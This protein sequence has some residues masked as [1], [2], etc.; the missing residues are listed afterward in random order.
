M[1]V[2]ADAD[3]FKGWCDCWR[4][5]DGWWVPGCHWTLDIVCWKEEVGTVGEG[6][7]RL[8]G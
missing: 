1:A 4:R 8:V 2:V 5:D 7:W 3:G 6:R